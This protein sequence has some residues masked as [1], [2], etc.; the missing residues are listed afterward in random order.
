LCLAG[1]LAVVF[2][3]QGQ[4]HAS[5]DDKGRLSLG[6][7]LKAKLQDHGENSIVVTYYD[8]GLQGYTLRQWRRLEKKVAQRPRFSRSARSFALVFLGNANELSVDKQGRIL[9]PQHLRE[10]A[11]LGGSVVIL[12]YMDTLEIWDRE[13][14]EERQGRE[15]ELMEVGT[16]VDDLVVPLDGDEE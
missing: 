16:F 7:R 1:A 8:G 13:R 6:S 9:I 4:F 5:L 14:L 3:V 12:S 10:R 11:G 15:A 2:N